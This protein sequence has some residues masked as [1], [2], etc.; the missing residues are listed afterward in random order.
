MEKKASDK[1]IRISE[2]DEVAAL[3]A[4]TDAAVDIC[5]Q[6]SYEEQV[7]LEA[8]LKSAPQLPLLEAARALSPDDDLSNLTSNG[9]RV[10]GFPDLKSLCSLTMGDDAGRRKA[11]GKHKQMMYTSSNEISAVFKIL[12]NIRS[13]IGRLRRSQNTSNSSS[14]SAEELK[15]HM[16]LQ[17]LLTYLESDLKIHPENMPAYAKGSG[18]LADENARFQP[19]LSHEVVKGSKVKNSADKRNRESQNGKVNEKATASQVLE[20]IKRGLPIYSQSSSA[21]FGK[22]A[23][24]DRQKNIEIKNSK[25]NSMMTL[26]LNMLNDSESKS[27]VRRLFD[28]RKRKRNERRLQAKERLQAVVDDDVAW[29]STD[30]ISECEF[31]DEEVTN[32]EQESVDSSIVVTCP[33]CSLRFQLEDSQQNADAFLS[34]H[35][36]KCQK[37]SGRVTRAHR[38]IAAGGSI[39]TSEIV[40]KQIKPKKRK[41]NSTP[42]HLRKRRQAIDDMDDKCY[43]DRV[44]EWMTTG[45]L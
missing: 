44:Y 8:T 18:A 41:T 39:I 45:I 31:N 42:I 20:R 13:E 35:M 2:E 32:N 27:D 6:S 14:E 10:F 22:Q 7:L 24:V 17:I 12:S 28:R 37:R 16:K 36:N 19:K 38:R 11:G 3:L 33:I 43:D 29:D 5:K 1:D 9:P 26:K 23:L 15:L 30:D 4:G 34:D 25:R 40:Q 21:S